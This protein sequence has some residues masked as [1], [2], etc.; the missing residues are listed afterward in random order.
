MVDKS[1]A[2]SYNTDAFVQY[3][4]AYKAENKN[5]RDLPSP[6]DEDN[7]SRFDD[8]CWVSRPLPIYTTEGNLVLPRDYRGVLLGA[9]VEVHATVV[10]GRHPESS[11]E[12]FFFDTQRMIVLPNNVE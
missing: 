7:L 6:A 1:P 8:G 9:A 3:W 11:T 4:T 5:V 2:H 12:G 10:Y